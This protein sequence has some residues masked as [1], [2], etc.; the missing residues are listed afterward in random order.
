MTRGTSSSQTPSSL[1]RSISNKERGGAPERRPRSNPKE[2]GV[3]TVTRRRRR[4]RRGKE[5]KQ[6]KRI[7]NATNPKNRK[8][9]FLV[10]QA[11][12]HLMASSNQQQLQN[13]KELIT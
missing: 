12:H 7:P 11:A 10:E 4:R 13:R 2:I 1:T 3:F 9:S 8:S 6:Q 5:F